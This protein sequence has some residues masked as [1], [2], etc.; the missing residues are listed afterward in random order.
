VGAVLIV[1][2]LMLLAGAFRATGR[3]SV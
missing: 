2:G 3:R 1:I